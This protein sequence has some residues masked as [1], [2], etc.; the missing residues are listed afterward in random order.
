MNAS[1]MLKVIIAL[2]VIEGIIDPNKADALADDAYAALAGLRL[3]DII[4][5][6]ISSIVTEV[7]VQRAEE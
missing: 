3:E 7:M 1:A 2:L 5:K 6:P 4:E